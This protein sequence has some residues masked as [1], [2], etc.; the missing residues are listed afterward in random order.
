M[1]RV[2]CGPGWWRHAAAYVW[3]VLVFCGVAERQVAAADFNVASP[4]VRVEA[5]SLKADEIGN[6]LLALNDAG[7]S[8]RR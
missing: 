2:S 6:R 8:G 7:G 3:V 5:D 1:K 4:G